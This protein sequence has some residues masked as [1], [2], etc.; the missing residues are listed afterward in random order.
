MNVG[1]VWEEVDLPFEDDTT[2]SKRRPCIIIE[3]NKI[4]LKH[5]Y[6]HNLLL[7]SHILHL[8]F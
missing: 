7:N 2:Q 6:N 3:V 5:H 4:G 1:E 8:A